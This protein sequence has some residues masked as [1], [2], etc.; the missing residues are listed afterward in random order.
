MCAYVGS[1]KNLKAQK[2]HE[3]AKAGALPGDR[4]VASPILFGSLDKVVAPKQLRISSTSPKAYGGGE[5]RS[6]LLAAI[7]CYQ[8][9]PVQ[10]GQTKSCKN[11]L[12]SEK[13]INFWFASPPSFWSGCD[14]TRHHMYYMKSCALYIE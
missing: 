5:H 13:Q 4:F 1:S 11:Q 8:G 6:D 9:G 2:E 14:K 7:F 10:R 12:F 3:G